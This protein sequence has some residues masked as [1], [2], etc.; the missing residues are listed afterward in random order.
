MRCLLLRGFTLL[1]AF[2]SAR[3]FAQTVGCSALVT[4]APVCI[5]AMSFDSDPLGPRT[6]LLF[7]HGWQ[8]TATA[9]APNDLDFVAAHVSEDA[10]L[11][12]KFKPYIVTY[13]SNIVAADVLAARFHEA[14]DTVAIAD[15][16]FGSRPVAI[17]AHSMGGLVSRSSMRRTQNAGAFAGAAHGFGV[18]RLI[19]LG[20]PHH[21]SPAANGSAREA[22]VT[23]ASAQTA[24]AGVEAW[25][26]LPYTQPN[27]SDLRWDNYD[28][29][30]D[31]GRYPEANAWLVGLNAETVFDAKLIAYAGYTDAPNTASRCY[32]NLKYCATAALLSYFPPGRGDGIVPV[33]S[34]HFYAAGASSPRAGVL[35]R[36]LLGYDHTQLRA[37]RDGDS[38]LWDLLRADLLDRVP[39]V[40]WTSAPPSTV[41]S[42]QSYSVAWRIN[43]GTR[44]THSNLHWHPVAAWQCS[45]TANP[46]CSTTSSV[47]EANPGT[48]TTYSAT[49][50]APAVTA[51]TTY[52]IAAHAEVNGATTWSPFASMRVVPPNVPPPPVTIT[53]GLTTLPGVSIPSLTPIFY[54]QSVA[55]ADGYDVYLENAAG[56]VIYH[57]STL[58]ASATWHSYPGSLAN[59]TSYRWSARAHNASGWS[60]RSPRRYFT[61]STGQVARDFSITAAQPS[62]SVTAGATVSFIINTATTSGTPQMIA[63]SA[64]NLPPNVQPAFSATPVQSGNSSTFS[65]TTTAATPAGVYVISVTGSGDAGPAHATTVSL[66]VSAPAAG[67][68][69]ICLSPSS[70]GFS[71]QMAGTSSP[72]QTVTL[73]NCGSG[74][75]HVSSFGASVDFF[76]ALGGIQAPFDL[77]A[78]TATSYQVG[79][80]PLST[81]RRDGTVKIFS[82]APDSPAVQPL[83]GVGTPAPVTTGT[84]NV[85]VAVNGVSWQGYMPFSLTWPTGGTMNF[86]DV[87]FSYPSQ[88]AGAYTVAN[89]GSSPAGGTLTSIAPAAT[90]TL[91]A[92]GAI[93]FTFNFTAP[94]LYQLEID[95]RGASVAAGQSTTFKARALYQTGSTQMITLHVYGLPA[96]ATYSANPNPVTLSSSSA[97][98]AVTIQTAADTLPGLYSLQVSAANAEGLTRTAELVLVVVRPQMIVRESVSSAGDQTDGASNRPSMTGDGRSVAYISSATNLLSDSVT[99]PQAF[100]RDRQTGQVRLVSLTTAGASCDS[101]VYGVAASSDGRY[102][103]FVSDAA[104]VTAG[105]VRYRPAVYVR[106]LLLQTTT[107]VSTTPDGTVANEF[108][109]MPSLSSDGRFVCF[110]SSASNLVPAADTSLT[111][112]YVKDMKSGALDLVSVASDGTPANAYSG[113][114]AMSADG[115][116][117]AFVSMA[118][119]LTSDPTSGAQV[120]VHD[121]V[122]KNTTMASIA[123]SGA[124]NGQ[125]FSNLLPAV[126]ADGRYVA[127]SS[128]ATNLV[129]GDTGW[130]NR[131]YL[132]DRVTNTTRRM[133]VFYPPLQEDSSINPSVTADGRFVIANTNVPYIDRELLIWDTR[134][135]HT[136]VATV[137]ANGVMTGY[138]TGDQGF[139]AT[140]DPRGSLI[141]FSSTASNLV[142]NDTNGV[143]DIF[144]VTNPN[145][146]AVH[147]TAVTLSPATIS[148]GISAQGSVTL[149]APAPAGGA[150]ITLDSSDPHVQV[151]ATVT[152]PPGATSAAFTVTTT[153]VTGETPLTVVASYGGGSPFTVLTLIPPV[154]ASVV[155]TSGSQQ[156]AAVS[157][158]FASPLQAQV[159][160]TA[161]NAVANSTVTFTAPAVEPSGTFVGG[162]RTVSGVTGANGVATAPAFTAGTM[163]GS[164]AIVASVAGVD[165]QAMFTL[166]NATAVLAAPANVVATATSPTNVAIGW[167]AVAGATSYDVYRRAA[168]GTLVKIAT[169]TSTSLNDSNVSPGNAYLFAVATRNGELASPLGGPD[170]ATTVTFG[171]TV[172]PR[173]TIV[174]AAQLEELRS[175]MTSLSALAGVSVAPFTDASLSHVRVKAAHILELRA[176]LSAARAALNLP[177]VIFTNPSLNTVSAA[178]VN[179]LR[180]GLK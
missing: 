69:A 44:V 32:D 78:D 86:G 134:T 135:D 149:N 40:S 79:F 168:G 165:N 16:A 27:R 28:G 13:N 14:L 146:D 12:A 49:F 2:T 119:N 72:L 4:T 96:G 56:G 50:T 82:N 8:F 111:R 62:L 156:S 65:V 171:E 7:V 25:L 47:S 167:S 87:P 105:S 30:F 31:Y 121:R 84:V 91:E 59:D 154:P 128:R 132:R 48:A 6:P 97:E 117:I 64:L 108:S 172:T 54:W 180:N 29:L 139:A 153:S 158:V 151:P 125:A 33:P 35:T 55:G 10:V 76:I 110:I 177:P 92:G 169:V 101:G 88:P 104:N 67:D 127:F 123:L 81:G 17:I 159:L 15:V 106:D 77:P 42:G 80:A 9:P 178:D 122:A 60:D 133:R 45:A 166:T 120:Y 115:R 68:A 61:V 85:Q 57:S 138:P 179:D 131:V 24:V 34:A 116:I 124:P 66:T 175:A 129:A 174:K 63:L 164:Y 90:Q 143:E 73:R 126:S 37:G 109:T 157:T 53:P 11:S 1:I 163:T 144:I 103:A 118:T 141:A 99:S 39:T 147:A 21:G 98:S 170:L 3:G 71:D 155:A 89:S 58:A 36:T 113:Y 100:L 83:T 102:V 52:S 173:S 74:P 107:L 51:A 140:I 70:L 19:T 46:A 136:V 148:G 38:Q 162:V 95:P 152:I 41:T 150:T 93:L 137:N 75:L 130:S 43:G 142:S 20:T 160:D 114:P 161:G 18:I 176:A 5:S 112:V 145:V 22:Y 26:D 94:N 23:S